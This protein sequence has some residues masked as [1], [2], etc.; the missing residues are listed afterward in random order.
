[1]S[2]DEIL[3]FI[4]LLSLV[5]FV[6]AMGAQGWIAFLDIYAFFSKELERFRPAPSQDKYS[7]IVVVIG[8]LILMKG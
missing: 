8:V 7:R 3:E 1:M 4:K 6:S 2:I 5:V